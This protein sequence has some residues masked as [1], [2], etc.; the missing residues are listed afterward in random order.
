MEAWAILRTLG[1]LVVVLGLLAGALWAVRRFDLRLPGAVGGTHGRRLELVERLGIDQRR[2]AVLLRRD[3]QEHLII[4]SPE[5]HLL[6][7]TTSR[8]LGALVEPEP[9]SAEIIQVE[10]GG[11]ERSFASLVETVIARSGWELPSRLTR[12][13]KRKA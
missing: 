2:S 13:F 5:G 3:D 11:V 1:A 9:E 10:S 7:E 6:V 8:P 4:V 12:L